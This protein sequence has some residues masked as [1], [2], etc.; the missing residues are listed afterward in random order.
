MQRAAK[1]RKPGEWIVGRGWDQNLWPDTSMPH[2]RDLS[3]ATPDNPVWLVRV[4]GQAA[5]ANASV[6]GKRSIMGLGGDGSC[7]HYGR[8]RRR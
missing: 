2:H 8:Q 3:A 6:S 4:D 7:A 5:L 1:G